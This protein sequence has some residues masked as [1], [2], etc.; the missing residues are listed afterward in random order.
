MQ[1]GA[2][3]PDSRGPSARPWLS[4][5]QFSAL[6]GYVTF[7]EG[8]PCAHPGPAPGTE[9]QR[10]PRMAPQLQTPR[11][12]PDGLPLSGREVWQRAPRTSVTCSIYGS[13]EDEGNHSGA[14][15]RPRMREPVA[16]PITPALGKRLGGPPWPRPQPPASPRGAR[17]L[18]EGA[19]GAGSSAPLPRPRLGRGPGRNLGSVPRSCR[20]AV[21]ADRAPLSCRPRRPPTPRTTRREEPAANAETE[22]A[23]AA[24]AARWR[25][26]GGVNACVLKHQTVSRLLL[27]SRENASPEHVLGVRFGPSA[28]PG[29]LEA[30]RSPHPA[31]W[32][33][34]LGGSRDPDGSL[35]APLARSTLARRLLFF[36]LL[37]HSAKGLRKLPAPGPSGARSGG[38]RH[39][40]GRARPAPP[41]PSPGPL[42]PRRDPSELA[43]PRAAPSGGGVER[44]SSPSRTPEPHAERAVSPPEPRCAPALPERLALP[45]PAFDAGTPPSPLGPPGRSGHAPRPLCSRSLSSSLAAGLGLAWLMLETRQPGPAPPRRVPGGQTGS[46]PGP[47]VGSASEPPSAGVPGRRTPRRR[48]TGAGPGAALQARGRRRDPSGRVK[49][50]TRPAPRGRHTSPAGSRS[51]PLPGPRIPPPAPPRRPPPPAPLPRPSFSP[52]PPRPGASGRPGCA[53]PGR[54]PPPDAELGPARPRPLTSGFA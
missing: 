45:T 21:T 32:D 24:G 48:G 2:V 51:L 43:A 1:Q 54:G 52:A 28:L 5:L 53:N 20:R 34:C 47:G 26:N 27:D 13:G 6:P 9:Q 44:S 29:S 40:P 38:P 8:A 15:K 11:I 33:V 4:S 14:P 22:T 16:A 10:G 36:F 12:A 46:R 35:P 31:F 23:T 49:L 30:P 39:A 7:A 37:G 17:P 3:R 18:G 25:W 42:R 41:A 50:P 19:A